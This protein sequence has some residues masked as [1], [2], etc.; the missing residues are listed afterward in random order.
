[1]RMLSGLLSA[2]HRFGACKQGFWCPV[3]HYGLN[4]AGR[5][6]DHSIQRLQG[7]G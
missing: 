7:G 6:T 5:I 2:R 3:H 4:K 1:M